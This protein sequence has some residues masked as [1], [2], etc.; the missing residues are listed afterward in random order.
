MADD[1]DKVLR[2][3]PRTQEELRGL[4]FDSVLGRVTTAEGWLQK[5][6]FEPTLETGE[7]A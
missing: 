6:P 2:Q 1:A 7:F 5:S 4:Y 3:V